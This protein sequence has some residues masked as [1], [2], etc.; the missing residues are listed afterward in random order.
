[1][2][3]EL[4]EAALEGTGLNLQGGM[5]L[6]R[7]SLFSFIASRGFFWTLAVSW[8]M[9]PLILLFVWTA[10]AGNGTV[11]GLERPVFVSYYLCLII[12]NQLTYPTSHWVI[13]D[14]IRLGTLSTWLLRPLPI[15]YEAVASDIALKIVCMPLVLVSVAGLAVFMGSGAGITP[16]GIAI[17]MPVL[18][19]SCVLRFLTAYTLSLFAMWTQK[20]DSLLSV[21]D[22]LVFLLAGQAAPTILLPGVLRTVSEYLPFRYMLGF[23]VEIVTGMLSYRQVLTGLLVQAVWL[24]AAMAVQRIVYRRGIGRFNAIGG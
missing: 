20:I 9:P 14:N 3:I 8:M 12:V 10:A 24:F 6:I 15:I 2:R 7:K 19:I 13:G 21:N 18:L 17:S 4:K 23:P 1:M 5:A 16:A 11:G 22:I